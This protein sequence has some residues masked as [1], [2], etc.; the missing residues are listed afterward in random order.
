MWTTY[1]KIMAYIETIKKGKKNFYYLTQTIR[2]KDKFKK[3]RMFLGKGS[4]SQDKL[5]KLAKLAEKP[6]KEKV[7]NIKIINRIIV[8][9]KEV[10]KKLEKIKNKYKKIISSFSK[11]E[12]SVVEK[13]HLI[14]FTFNT[15][16]IEGST[17]TLKETAH[18]L[19]DGIS[20]EGKDLREIY[21]VENTKKAYNF[22]KKHKKEINLNFIKKIHYHLTYNILG[23]SSGCF[24]RIQVYMAGSKHIPTK[25]SEVSKEMISLMRWV[26]NHSKLHPVVLAAYVH[27]FFIAIH[28]FID[29]NG[30]VGRLLLNFMLM[31][32][33]FPPICIKKEERIKYTDY[34]E[35]A[36]DGDIS[37]FL[38][39]IVKKI[40]EVYN[41]LV[42]TIK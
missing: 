35:L 40:E 17:I 10:V 28:P 34:L 19:E 22:M 16:A 13:Q 18:I 14:K 31:K 26:R 12:Y 32:S 33:G 7:K 4:I 39:F 27:H 36:R 3:V 37:K 20:P 29:G 21:E 15:N 1:S 5:K 8:L 24:R 30:R 9:D 42:D 41:E 2:L 6:L 38:D 11:T 23:D 25:T